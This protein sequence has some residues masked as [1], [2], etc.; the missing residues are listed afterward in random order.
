MTKPRSKR[1]FKAPA[2][3]LTQHR[4]RPEESAPPHDDPSATGRAPRHGAGIRP[5]EGRQVPSAHTYTS[6]ID[7]RPSCVV[8]RSSSSV[9][10]FAATLLLYR[11]DVT[12]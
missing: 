1:T 11:N 7:W 10:P 8:R 9:P 6:A 2:D 3:H 4:G 5:P 12:P